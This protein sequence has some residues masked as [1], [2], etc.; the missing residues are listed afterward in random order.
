MILFNLAIQLLIVY[1]QN[2]R[3]PHL[4]LLIDVLYVVTYVK[5][6][7][8]AYRTLKGGDKDPLVTMA[9]EFVSAYSKAAEMALQVCMCCCAVRRV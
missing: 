7:V 5:P 6:G 8:D 2:L 3:K 1:S 4:A 9:P